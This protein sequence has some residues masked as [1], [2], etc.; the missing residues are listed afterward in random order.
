MIQIPEHSSIFVNIQEIYQTFTKEDYVRR[1]KNWILVVYLLS[2][3]KMNSKFISKVFLNCLNLVGVDNFMKS[4]ITSGKQ[5]SKKGGPCFNKVCF[6]LIFFLHRTS[7]S[8]PTKVEKFPV[9]VFDLNQIWEI[10]LAETNLKP[11]RNALHLHWMVE[12]GSIVKKCQDTG[13]WMRLKEIETKDL[14]KGFQNKTCTIIVKN[15][16]KPS[17]KAFYFCLIL[18][19][20]FRFPWHPELFVKLIVST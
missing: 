11:F 13:V 7:L 10:A 19:D 6:I 15:Y 14:W 9:V 12:I 20:F 18:C 1:Q 5:I 8:W 2:Q 16:A 3:Q 4:V 17:I